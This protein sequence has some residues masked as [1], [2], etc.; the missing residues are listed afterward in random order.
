MDK[1]IEDYLHLY[2]G[3]EFQWA[4][5]YNYKLT[6]FWLSQILKNPDINNIK[7]ILRPLSDMIKK[8]LDEVSEIW[9]HMSSDKNN[10]AMQCYAASVKYYLSKHFDLFGLIPEGLAIDATTLKK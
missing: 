3:C 9:I 8:E 1:K 2:L 5:K 6:A 10:S 7:P 4:G